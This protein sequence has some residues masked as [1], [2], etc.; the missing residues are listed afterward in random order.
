MWIFYGLAAIAI[1]VLRVKE[2]DV[3]R[4]YRCWGYPWCPDS[5]CSRARA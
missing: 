1:F 5:S 2:P 3:P 4:P